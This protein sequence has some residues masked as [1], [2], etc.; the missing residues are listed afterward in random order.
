MRILVIDDEREF[1]FPG[2]E[3]IVYAK[4]IEDAFTWI[5]YYQ[6]WDQVWLDHDLGDGIDVITFCNM[7]EKTAYQGRLYNIGEFVIHSMN[8]VGR[9]RMAQALNKFYNVRFVMPEDYM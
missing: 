7:V 1:K 5:K 9:A 8:P 3:K 6:R 2:A 4:S